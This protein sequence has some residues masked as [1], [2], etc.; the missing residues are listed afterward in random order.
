MLPLRSQRREDRT[1]RPDFNRTQRSGLCDAACYRDS[2]SNNGPWLKV[3]SAY[4]GLKFV[5][6]RKT[7]FGWAT[8]LNVT[9]PAEDSSYLDRLRLRNHPWQVDH[10][11]RD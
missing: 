3:K 1:Q 10:R 6:K 7:H 11:R 2:C 4:L 5:I 9:C 8:Q